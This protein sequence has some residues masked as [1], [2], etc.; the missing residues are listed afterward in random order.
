MTA[1]GRWQVGVG[2]GQAGEVGLSA[3]RGR[4]DPRR[5]RSTLQFDKAGDDGDTTKG[6]KTTLGRRPP[7]G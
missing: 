3:R 1:G 5:R 4:L 6:Q 7:A 2:G